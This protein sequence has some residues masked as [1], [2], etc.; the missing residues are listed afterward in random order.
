MNKKQLK[1]LDKALMRNGVEEQLPVCM[2]EPAEM[3]QAITKAERY[4]DK[5][6]RIGNVIEEIAD[7][8]IC[9]EYLKMIYNI[10]QSEID[11][12]IIKKTDRVNER[13]G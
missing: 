10:D 4:P 6:N 1:I 9:I 8:S 2:E 5:V 7:F 3:I 13:M 11:E 12:M